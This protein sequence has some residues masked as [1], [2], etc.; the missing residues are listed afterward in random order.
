MLHAHGDN[1]AQKI[2]RDYKGL[3]PV[4]RD[5][6]QRHYLP[7]KTTSLAAD[8]SDARVAVDG[9]TAGFE[10]YLQ[11]VRS[12]TARGAIGGAITSQ[13]GFE[14]TVL[15]EFCTFLFHRLP[16]VVEHDEVVL[17]NRGVYMGMSV[18]PD[19]QV[20]VRKKDSDFC[21][22]K[23]VVLEAGGSTRKLL[24]PLVTVECKTS[25]VD[26]T[27]LSS[28]LFSARQGR[29][30]A[31][32]MSSYVIAETKSFDMSLHDAP[33]DELFVFKRRKVDPWDRDTV[34]DFYLELEQAVTRAVSG[35]AVHPPGR[36]VR[37]GFS[38]VA[39][40]NQGSG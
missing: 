30:G 15:E 2:V 18:R 34:F 26:K 13:S 4:L 28:L 27:M 10:S 1:L 24:V 25:Y 6:R 19:G 22:A 7:W 40:W 17:V 11:A 20:S 35:A 23:R 31:V 5:W 37:P 29:Q 8:W 9:L 16:E 12:F 32:G 38:L 39:G 21:I 36:V 14:S 3:A 33:I